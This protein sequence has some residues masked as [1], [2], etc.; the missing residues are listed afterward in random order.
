MPPIARQAPPLCYIGPSPSPVP[1]DTPVLGA[2]PAIQV[3]VLRSGSY[4]WLAELLDAFA[5]GDIGRYDAL[6]AGHAATLNSQ[7]A[8]VA[9]ERRLREKITLLS[10]ME[11]VAT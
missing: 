3:G 7:P 1:T 2:P 4:S 8:L 10:L 11:L 9:H 6:C 5:D